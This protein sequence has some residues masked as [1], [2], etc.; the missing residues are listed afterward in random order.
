MENISPIEL[1]IDGHSSSNVDELKPTM[2]LP[3]NFSIKYAA[4]PGAACAIE[5]TDLSP[6][7]SNSPIFELVHWLRC[8]WKPKEARTSDM[9]APGLT[10]ETS[11]PWEPGSLSTWETPI[12]KGRSEIVNQRITFTEGLQ[13]IY[14][15]YPDSLGQPY[16]IKN[17]FGQTLPTQ[18]CNPWMRVAG[19]S[20]YQFSLEDIISKFQKTLA[21]KKISADYP[22]VIYG[23]FCRGNEQD[24]LEA[25]E[26]AY[27]TSD[28]LKL[29][30]GV[31][32]R[33]SGGKKRRKKK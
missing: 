24:K 17:E 2:T 27:L 14:V 9:P 1:L 12:V 21:H 11:E 33:T 5:E 31:C 16:L 13:G 29:F 32:R 19:L 4:S 26:R 7:N 22:V 18:V 10:E 25:G 30:T 8:T 15:R 28:A 6:N 20:R 3:D 23:V